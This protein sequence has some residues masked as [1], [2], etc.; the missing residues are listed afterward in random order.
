M[1]MAVYFEHKIPYWKTM[2][3]AGLACLSLTGCRDDFDFDSV[4]QDLD[5][6]N[7]FS[8]STT[9]KQSISLRYQ[10]FGYGPGVT[11]SVYFELYTENPVTENH[12]SNVRYTKK[13]GVY[14]FFAAYTNEDGT[15]SRDIEIPAY[16]DK[17]Y[18]YSP[19]G[20]VQALITAD[21]NG[22]HVVLS[23]GGTRSGIAKLPANTLA[24]DAEEPSVVGFYNIK[25]N[26]SVDALAT[27][28][29]SV[30]FKSGNNY[31]RSNGGGALT[32]GNSDTRNSFGIFRYGN[33]YYLYNRDQN[34]WLYLNNNSFALTN[35]APA[36]TTISNYRVEL[37]N[38]TSGN[39]IIKIGNRYLSINNN[40]LQ[41]V[42]SNGTSWAIS[43]GTDLSDTQKTNAI[44]ALKNAGLKET[45]NKTEYLS[46]SEGSLIVTESESAAKNFAIIES[47]DYKYLYCVDSEK[48]LEGPTLTLNVSPGL[49]FGFSGTLPTTTGST[50]N[51][52]TMQYDGNIGLT[53]SA[54]NNNTYTV[55]LT[56]TNATNTSWSFTKLPDTY[57]VSDAAFEAI[58]TQENSIDG[59]FGDGE[60]GHLHYT[61]GVHRTGIPGFTGTDPWAN[62]TYKPDVWKT[63]LGLYSNS[64]NT[65][66][67][68]CADHAAA[69]EKIQT[70]NYEVN[71]F[72]ELC[73]GV[74]YVNKAACQEDIEKLFYTKQEAVDTYGSHDKVINKDKSC[75]PEFL[76]NN[77]EITMTKDAALAICYIGNA[78]GWNSSLAYY[79]Y[80]TK[81]N[82]ISEIHPI[83]IFP[84]TLDAQSSSGNDDTA[85][86]AGV[87][88]G[89][90]IQLYYYGPTNSMSKDK[91][92]RLF[93]AGTHIGFMFMGHAWQAQG[94]GAHYAWSTA[95]TNH[96]V[97]TT[98]YNQGL[99]GKST[100]GTGEK[101]WKYDDVPGGFGGS[102]LWSDDT[103]L[104]FS[105]EDNKDD[106][107]ASDIVF[108]LKSN[109]SGAWTG[110]I[111]VDGTDQITPHQQVVYTFED[112]WPKKGDYDMNDVMLDTQLFRTLSTKSGQV[113]VAG[114]TTPRNQTKQWVSK[115]EYVFQSYENL[116]DYTNGLAIKLIP[117]QSHALSGTVQIQTSDI[118]AFVKCSGKTTFSSGKAA[119]TKVPINIDKIVRNDDGS[120]YIYITDNIKQYSYSTE[121]GVTEP[122][123][124][125]LVIDY[126]DVTVNEAARQFV[127][128]GCPSTNYMSTIEPFI[129]RW[130]QGS[131]SS[132]GKTWEVHL[133]DNLPSPL[134]VDYRTTWTAVA[135]D[136][137]FLSNGGLD[138][139]IST[140]T[141]NPQHFYVRNGD[142]PFALKL[143]NATV[144]GNLSKLLIKNN[145][146][147]PIDEVYPG[148]KG[149][150]ESKGVN[151]ADWY[152]K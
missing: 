121:R 53:L 106:Y 152:L 115:E 16:A 94:S 1:K 59:S 35:T 143:T 127:T 12:D 36:S 88:R 45:V 52:I 48:F 129:Y 109:P 18:A 110:V 149:W 93:P 71:S 111:V 104:V 116:A 21:V 30:K 83:L 98:G 28:V 19:S 100:G 29:G 96:Y 7:L 141:T 67:K 125:H 132:N 25:M 95:S 131:A 2:V 142:Y 49:L 55:Q 38:E 133:Q 64:C 6:E 44:N 23:D 61:Q 60:S 118:S 62:D 11:T 74:N 140:P 150:V 99:K 139:D 84:N 128:D 126:K 89:S 85:K 108:G 151:N 92:S 87:V 130:D 124:I 135:K 90:N 97:T 119:G 32:V 13:E 91:K 72:T 68:D 114:Q 5:V 31:V 20:I 138:G 147:K 112:L 15:W 79:Y 37:Q 9:Q 102:A 137:L 117:D 75:P 42:T 8:F 86:R 69:A 148:F 80:E 50:S 113:V 65:F 146:T 41:S 43:N 105:F 123:E 46:E 76:G 54:N 22:D 81:P 136:Y 57:T 122:D 17:I 73:G 10:D 26:V 33:Y 101:E 144:R 3:I 120:L 58:K 51:N 4:R 78:T 70:F 77:Q 63:W 66:L 14:P 34:R 27:Y 134:N 40:A 24:S 145:E 107:N 56:T 47:S 39:T 82:N 103:H